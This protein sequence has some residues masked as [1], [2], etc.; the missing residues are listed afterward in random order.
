MACD[1]QLHGGRIFLRDI[2]TANY[3]RAIG[4]VVTPDWF[5]ATKITGQDKPGSLGPR[6]ANTAPMPRPQVL[7]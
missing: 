6:F 1:Y 5:A 2:E 3:A 4:D 7:Q